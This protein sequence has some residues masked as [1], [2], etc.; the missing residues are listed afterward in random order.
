MQ[1]G[2]CTEGSRLYDL[3]QEKSVD[4][5]VA[6][7]EK[8]LAVSIADRAKWLE[9]ARRVEEIR[10]ECDRARVEYIDHAASCGCCERDGHDNPRLHAMEVPGVAMGQRGESAGRL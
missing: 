8:H 7:G 6:D 1:R 5:M 4:W 9:I 2:H 3:Y 10:G